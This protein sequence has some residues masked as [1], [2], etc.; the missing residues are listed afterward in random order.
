MLTVSTVSTN[1]VSENAQNWN[2]E[3]LFDA[4]G[5]T[6]RHDDEPSRDDKLRRLGL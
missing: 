2:A 6:E 1:T 5:C 3:L 4:L